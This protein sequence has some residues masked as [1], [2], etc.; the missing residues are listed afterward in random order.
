[1]LFGTTTLN[2]Q[3]SNSPREIYRWTT[4]NSVVVWMSS[5]LKNLK[6]VELPLCNSTCREISWRGKHSYRYR[7]VHGDEPT[8][9]VGWLID[10]FVG[11]VVRH[12]H[13]P[14]PPN[15]VNY[16]GWTPTKGHGNRW[17][18]LCYVSITTNAVQR[19][20][21]ANQLTEPINR[22]AHTNTQSVHQSIKLQS[23]GWNM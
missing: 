21:W 8:L 12:R 23:F 5:S 9:L 19:D 1:M 22:R 16:V 6:P 20:K 17:L 10:A 2:S 14:S 18:A 3:P 13:R 11:A 7:Y 15:I 4:V